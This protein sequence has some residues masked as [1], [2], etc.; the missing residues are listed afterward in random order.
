MPPKKAKSLEAL[1]PT[2]CLYNPEPRVT[3]K[4]TMSLKEKDPAQT[5]GEDGGSGLQPQQP[6]YSNVPGWLYQPPPRVDDQSVIDAAIKKSRAARGYAKRSF[7]IFRDKCFDFLKDKENPNNPPT[8]Q[9][10]VK[11]AYKK[12]CNAFQKVEDCHYNLIS[13]LD[14]NDAEAE[15]E[16]MIVVINQMVD[17]TDAMGDWAFS[18][19]VPDGPPVV[20]R[21]PLVPPPVVPASQKIPWPSS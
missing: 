18:P 10:K 16:G 6:S 7:N 21:I 11:E 12:A 13:F 8:F 9:T 15:D 17:L 3:R 5:K 14:E 19:T 2:H 20:P 1:K 4:A